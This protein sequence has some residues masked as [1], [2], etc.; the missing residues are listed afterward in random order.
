M[1]NTV[2][3]ESEAYKVEGGAI[4]VGRAYRM[5]KHQ[6]A[7]WEDIPSSTNSSIIVEQAIDSCLLDHEGD[8]V[9]RLDNIGAGGEG[10]KAIQGLNE[11]INSVNWSASWLNDTKP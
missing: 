8:G 1:G 10:R 5:G 4:K 11:I 6:R 7:I 2:F 3:V 9:R